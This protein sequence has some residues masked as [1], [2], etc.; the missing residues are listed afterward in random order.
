MSTLFAIGADALIFIALPWAVWRLMGR[1]LPLAVLSTTLTGPLFRL[2]LWRP[3][4]AGPQHD[5]GIQGAAASPCAKR[6]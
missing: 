1:S 4:R 2:C 3:G 6:G 5:Q